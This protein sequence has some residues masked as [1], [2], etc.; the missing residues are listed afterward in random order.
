MRVGL[1][2]S[3]RP[4][5]GWIGTKNDAV[6]DI[7][8]G[9]LMPAESA[10]HTRTWMTL[11]TPDLDYRP[12]FGAEGSP[13][14]TAAQL[15]WSGVANALASFEPVTMLVPPDYTQRAR[16]MLVS[17]VR[18]REVSFDNCWL[19][20]CG[21]TFVHAAGGS[22]C[23]VN[24]ESNGWDTASVAHWNAE[25]PVAHTVAGIAKVP[26]LDS[27]LALDG[28]ALHVD[29]A[30]TA[31][32][33]E[34]VVLDSG[35]PGWTRAQ[36]E[37]ELR[38]RLG[39]TAVIWLPTNDQVDTLATFAAPGVVL[40]HHQPDPGHPDHAVSEATAEL[41]RAAT[42]ARGRRLTVIGLPAPSTQR[43]HSYL[44]H[45]VA[46]DVVLLG[47]F[48]DPADQLAGQLLRRIYRGRQVLML[49]ARKITE[50]GGGIHSI[51]QQQPAPTSDQRLDYR[52]GN[53]VSA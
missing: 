15:A 53:L 40:V 9:M 22:V 46:N 16:R 19:R 5:S 1:P 24:W 32:L 39:V 21:P 25:P 20:D 49:D 31:L 17:G 50:T 41:L 33:T 27:P 10:W 18:I 14:L 4:E 30:G 6:S 52:T 42:D 23:A 47:V 2:T 38:L 43:G 36:V 8:V 37:A 7:P 28:G 45:Y 11:P 29:G 13:S 34:S 3:A 26:V 51:T 44:N 12:G 48:D 35:N